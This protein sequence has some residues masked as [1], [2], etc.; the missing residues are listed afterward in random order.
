MDKVIGKP[1]QRKHLDATVSN[2]RDKTEAYQKTINY[3]VVRLSIIAIV[4]R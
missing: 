3:I 2:N 1:K 4:C